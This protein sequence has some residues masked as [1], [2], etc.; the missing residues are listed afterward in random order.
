VKKLFD[1][2]AAMIPTPQLCFALVVAST[3]GRLAGLYIDTPGA[4]RSKAT[5]P[6]A[7]VH[8]DYVDSPFRRVLSV[9]PE[10][11]GDM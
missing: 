6:S 8:I 9:T 4:A 7:R 10:R 2:A 1:L 3:G 11:Y 5:E